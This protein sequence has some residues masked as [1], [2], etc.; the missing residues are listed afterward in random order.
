MMNNNKNRNRE[1]LPRTFDVDIE[2]WNFRSNRKGVINHIR[3]KRKS[4]NNKEDDN[5]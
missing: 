4:L 1:K 5:N 3:M 2:R